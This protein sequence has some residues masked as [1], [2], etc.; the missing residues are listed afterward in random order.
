MRGVLRSARR[1]CAA[2]AAPSHGGLRLRMVRAGKHAG[3][4]AAAGGGTAEAGACCLGVGRRRGMLGSGLSGVHPCAQE[5]GCAGVT[6][7]HAARAAMSRWGGQ[8]RSVGFWCWRAPS[9]CRRWDCRDTAVAGGS[10]LIARTRRA[11]RVGAALGQ[12]EVPPQPSAV[13]GT[14]VCGC[15]FHVLDGR[16]N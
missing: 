2:A 13:S 10:H 5:R 9:F 12:R 4:A 15:V 11:P 1:L 14:P 3:V 16:R 8:N 7:R 6:R